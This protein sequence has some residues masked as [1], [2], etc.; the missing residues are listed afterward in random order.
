MK[1]LFIASTAIVTPE[2]A[3]SRKLFMDALGLPLKPHED[4]DYYFSEN[5][6]GSTKAGLSSSVSRMR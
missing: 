6:G 4:S 2:P 5:I 1:I 3:Q